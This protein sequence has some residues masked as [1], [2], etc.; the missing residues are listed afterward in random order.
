MAW[1]KK[2]IVLGTLVLVVMLG[3]ISGGVAGEQ[4]A[5]PF[6][7]IFCGDS[8]FGSDSSSD[9]P[10]ILAQIV[11]EANVRNPDFF[12]YGGDG[13]DHDTEANYT[14]FKACLDKLTMPYRNVVGN[15]DIYV[16]ATKGYCREHQLAFFGDPYYT[17]EYEDSFFLVLDS[18]GHGARPWGIRDACSEEWDWMMQQLEAN[19]STHRNTFVVSH[20]P[21]YDAPPRDDHA[22]TDTTEAAE[23][24]AL[25]AESGVTMVLASHEHLFYETEWGGVPYIISGGAGAT[26]WPNGFY[27]YVEICVGEEITRKVIP[28]LKSIAI[29]SSV[30]AKAPFSVNVGNRM[31]FVA[32]GTDPTGQVV[33]IEPPMDRVWSSSH[34]SVGVIDPVTGVFE[35][36]SGAGDTGRAKVDWL[37]PLVGGRVRMPLAEKLQFRARGDVGGLGIGSDL[38]WQAIVGFEYLISDTTTINVGYRWMG[39]ENDGLGAAGDTDL[40]IQLDGFIIGAKFEM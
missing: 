21:P 31:G 10:E 23:F 18:A 12:L 9:H 38:T 19:V 29:Y 35:G 27:H 14:A 24:V 15:H 37:E 40:D 28:V 33:P 30:P 5:A 1:F 3:V 2:G 7:F 20:T 4:E 22:F 36:M 26:L 32:R 17:F 13:P 34:P 16:E 6:F 25:M 8:R 11:A 39:I